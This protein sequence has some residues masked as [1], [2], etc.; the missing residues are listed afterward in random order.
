M[1]N[2]ACGDYIES[3]TIE[4]ADE[5]SRVDLTEKVSFMII[6]LWL[7]VNIFI[8][9]FKVKLLET[10]IMQQ[11]C[12]NALKEEPKPKI[13]EVKVVFCE[14]FF[15]KWIIKFIVYRR[16][17]SKHFNAWS[18]LDSIQLLKLSPYATVHINFASK[19]SEYLCSYCRNKQ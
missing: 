12:S 16:T 5:K 11:G 2:C 14:W 18:V 1:E 6:F 17:N 8:S 19:F 7:Q 9:Y 3:F 13:I 15:V 10:S 4:D